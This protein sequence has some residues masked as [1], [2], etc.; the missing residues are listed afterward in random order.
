MSDPIPTA[1][2]RRYSDAD[3]EALIRKFER[4]VTAQG[5]AHRI[6]AAHQ[7]LTA[8]L[9]YIKRRNRPGAHARLRDL[10]RMSRKL[11]VEAR[12]V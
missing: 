8:W 9:P 1:G 3:K 7:E 12:D 10:E 11:I 6:D 2:T 4:D 5:T